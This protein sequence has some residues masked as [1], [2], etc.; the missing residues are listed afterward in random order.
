MGRKMDFLTD[1]MICALRFYTGDISW[2]HGKAQ[3]A[4]FWQ[5]RN[6][7]LTLNALFYEGIGN[8]LARAREHKFL[9]PIFLDDIGRLLNV[10]EDLIKAM[11]ICGKGAPLQRAYRVER[12][13]G[14]EEMRLAGHTISPT[15]TS[16][17]GFLPDYRNKKGLVLLDFMIG[18]GVP[19]A[20]MDRL[21]PCYSKAEEKEILLAPW[22]PL[23]IHERPLTE[24]EREIRDYDGCPPR[25]ACQVTVKKP[26]WAHYM[27]HGETE[28]FVRS[29]ADA[30]KRVL[31]AISQMKTPGQED[32]AAY[33]L[34]KKSF[35]DYLKVRCS[36]G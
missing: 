20:D 36:Q 11:W 16:Q 35:Q 18:Q 33:S 10:C 27:E 31:E 2:W 23:E 32:V 15:S 13:S 1:Q 30:G 4:A 17:N 8:E 3:E 12:M 24:K 9:N 26:K 19:R 6:A 5:D 34:W 28:H 14:F 7:Y 21:L 25:M 29:G 22:L